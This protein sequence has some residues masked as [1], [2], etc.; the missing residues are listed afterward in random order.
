MGL[1]EGMG[2]GI[3]MAVLAG[4]GMLGMGIIG[5]GRVRIKGSRI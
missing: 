2:M 4:V 3:R 5:I 1:L